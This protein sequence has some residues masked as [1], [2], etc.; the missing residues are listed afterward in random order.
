MSSVISKYVSIFSFNHVSSKSNL[1]YA[2]NS[3]AMKTNILDKL[4]IQ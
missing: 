4:A 2:D 1:K 3:G